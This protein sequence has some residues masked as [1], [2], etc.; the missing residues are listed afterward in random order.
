MYFRISQ[1][2][3]V[4]NNWNNIR[5]R[6][7]AFINSAFLVISSIHLTCP[8]I[9]SSLEKM[10]CRVL[11][12]RFCVRLCVLWS[13]MLYFILLS[14]PFDSRFSWSYISLLSLKNE[15]INAMLLFFIFSRYVN[16]EFYF[17][18]SRYCFARTYFW[19]T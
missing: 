3:E 15:N 13:N 17:S 4:W 18:T 19:R 16:K 5:L 2:R 12:I 1:E 14:Y 9:N 7:F 11:Q 8:T 10:N 6:S